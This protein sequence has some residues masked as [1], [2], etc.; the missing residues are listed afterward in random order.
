MRQDIETVLSYLL[1]VVMCCIFGYYIYLSFTV[2]ILLSV[3]LMVVLLVYLY[4]ICFINGLTESGYCILVFFFVAQIIGYGTLLSMVVRKI[5]IGEFHAY[6]YILVLLTGLL[7]GCSIALLYIKLDN[8]ES[9]AHKKKNGG[10]ILFNTDS[11]LVC[12]DNISVFEK[13]SRP[14]HKH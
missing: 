14:G 9:L 13:T 11:K 12:K 6:T 2:D 1:V 7:L 5:L 4:S 8:I 10:V 3:Y